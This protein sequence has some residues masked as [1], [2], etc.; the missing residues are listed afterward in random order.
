MMPVNERLEKLTVETGLVVG[1]IGAIIGLS[2]IVA[3]VVLWWQADFGRLAYP[4]TMRLV[5]PG[6]TLV[7]FGFQTAMAALM[8]GVLKMHR[9]DNPGND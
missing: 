2:L 4:F 8:A 5:V 7:A 1:L 3:V 6:V 9:R